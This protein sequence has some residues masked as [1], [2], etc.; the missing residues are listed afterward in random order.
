MD[1]RV[2]LKKKIVEE[3]FS[4]HS[5]ADWTI[6][7]Y[8]FS[9]A[10]IMA[11]LFEPS[12][13]IEHNIVVPKR[14]EERRNAAEFPVVYFIRGDNQ[15]VRQINNEFRTKM[16]QSFIVCSLERCE[17]LD[18][19]IHSKVVD[20]DFVPFEQRV[21]RAGPQQIY[22]VGKTLNSM[23]SVNYS[24][25]ATREVA[26]MLERMMSGEERR[27][28]LI[29]LDRSVD[30]YTP[31]LHFYTFRSLL[32]ELEIED[33][34]ALTK[35]YMDDK[36]WLMVKNVHL[37]AVNAVLKTQAQLLSKGAQKLEDKPTSKDLMEAVFKAP[38]AAQAK[39]TLSKMIDLVRKCYEHFEHLASVTE[40]EQSLATGY[41]KE[42]KRFKPNLGDILE[43]VK[44]KEIQRLDK[45][46]ILLL[47]RA[48]GYGFQMNE[49][50]MLKQMGLS[51]EEFSPSFPNHSCFKPLREK[52]EYKFDVS[53]YE[54]IL[55]DVLKNFI[56]SKTGHVTIT[57]LTRTQGSVKS[58][59]KSR[60]LSI[61]KDVMSKKLY[62]VYIIGSVTF[63]EIRVVNELSEALG[64]EI[65]IGAEEIV[66]TRRFI[67]LIKPRPVAYEE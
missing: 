13:F 31:L 47:L 53:R 52:R 49:A 58:L 54:P 39:K 51:E 6:L 21:F 57:S 26:E 17:G 34:E 61:K 29:V 43:F 65:I 2:P 42:G 22:S 60:L 10:V 12:E 33:M 9:T 23:F 7:V 41:D 3:V 59:R 15:S 27:G 30:L 46:R 64:V 56:E 20:V 4:A 19:M 11:N 55:A 37:G 48:D 45:L 25:S 28:E 14:I 67:E 18:P 50:E 5:A 62:C 32:E 44:D 1:I 66:T 38:A 36:I 8:D 35:E 40:L 24:T 63:E 16:Y